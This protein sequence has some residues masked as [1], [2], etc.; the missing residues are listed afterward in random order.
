MTSDFVIGLTLTGLRL[1]LVSD[2]RH[3]MIMSVISYHSYLL[4]IKK[5]FLK[6]SDFQMAQKTSCYVMFVVLFVFNV[7]EKIYTIIARNRA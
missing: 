6:L 2:C 5:I 7:S 1:C 4:L 3:S